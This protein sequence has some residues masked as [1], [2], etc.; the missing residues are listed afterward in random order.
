MLTFHTIFSGDNSA[1]TRTLQIHIPE[2]TYTS[3]PMY[4]QI[5]L[6]NC[7]AWI[8]FQGHWV[9]LLNK[10]TQQHKSGKS[11]AFAI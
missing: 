3:E 7:T 10:V 5:C 11:V 6:Y 4:L 8:C 9:A 1:T 2:D